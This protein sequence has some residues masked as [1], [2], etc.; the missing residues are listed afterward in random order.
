MPTDHILWSRFFCTCFSDC[1]ISF[2]LGS[3]LPS[4]YSFSPYGSK[5]SGG[6]DAD[7]ARASPSVSCKA[8][9]E[10]KALDILQ[11]HAS[12]YKSKSPTISDKNSQERDRGSCGVVGGG[13]S[14]GSVGGAGG[15]DRSADRP[16]TSPSQRLMS[17]HH[18]H[19]HLGYSLLPAQY[20]LPYAA[21]LSSTAIV[22]SQQ[23][24]TPSLYPPPRR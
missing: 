20:N 12:H 17:T 24:S 13:G 15:A 4:S 11:Q 22:A 18:H 10:S 7:K 2:F 14:C 21:G 1:L 3:Y 23:G 19:H 8:S 6:E 16:R 5:V 9:S